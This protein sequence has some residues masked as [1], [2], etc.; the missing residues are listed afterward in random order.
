M[1]SQFSLTASGMCKKN[2]EYLNHNCCPYYRNEWYFWNQLNLLLIVYHYDSWYEF[3]SYAIKLTNLL[4]CVQ[5]NWVSTLI[6]GKIKVL[7]TME[8]SFVFISPCQRTKNTYRHNTVLSR[9]KLFRCL[10]WKLWVIKIGL[11]I[12]KLVFH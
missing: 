8:N 7:S 3:N 10:R 2:F 11:V 1:T 5:A 6:W 9:N 12:F 4:K